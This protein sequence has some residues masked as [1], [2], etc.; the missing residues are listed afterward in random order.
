[1]GLA[2]VLEKAVDAGAR[3]DSWGDMYNDEIWSELLGE[4]DTP[5][6]LGRI[7]SG[8]RVPW[9]HVDI[10]IS[11]KFLQKEMDRAGREET[12]PPC[13]RY[14]KEGSDE[15]RRVCH[16]CGLKCDLK[17][18]PLQTA[19]SNEPVEMLP[20]R[21]DRSRPKPRPVPTDLSRESVKVRLVMAKWG[22]QAFV[23]HLDTVRNI[24][25]SLRRAGMDLVYSRGFHPLPK[26]ETGPPLP[27]GI[28]GLLEPMDVLLADPPSDADILDR[29]ND[30]VPA[31][32]AF[33]SARRIRPGEKSLNK[34]LET[35]RYVAM[36]K[37]DSDEAKVAIDRLMNAESLTVER[38]HKKKKKS[39][40]LRPFLLEAKLLDGQMPDLP[41]P[42]SDDQLPISLVFQLSNSG[43]ARVREILDIA[44]GDKAQDAIIVRTEITLRQK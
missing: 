24:T 21:R 28:S 22:R 36:V 30:A 38:M 10:G 17:T 29:L 43:G 16:N 7:P 32:M 40:D 3:Y 19:R 6:L 31:D 41:I 33:V 9:D 4:I 13:G 12:T 37:V 23:G 1:V 27:L 44:F 42:F 14:L 35:A 11:G 39:I 8:K 2:P 26:L 18:G 25:R 15:V 34:S 5:G 20:P